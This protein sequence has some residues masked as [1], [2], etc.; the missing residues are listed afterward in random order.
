[1]IYTRTKAEADKFCGYVSS[2]IGQYSGGGLTGGHKRVD[3]VSGDMSTEEQQAVIDEF[4][5]GSSSWIRVLFASVVIGMGTHLVCLYN[6][7]RIGQPSTLLAWVQELGR[8]GR[9][10]GDSEALLF[11]CRSGTTWK[12]CMKQFCT[13]NRCLR[14]QIVLH[15]DPTVQEEVIRAELLE[16]GFE[17][18]CYVCDDI[19]E[20]KIN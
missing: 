6:V 5:R 9:D 15:F 3:K 7:W 4:A 2:K 11:F 20:Q 8:A 14:L 10:G 1:M 19:S 16:A 18:C 12:S 17:Y 13:S